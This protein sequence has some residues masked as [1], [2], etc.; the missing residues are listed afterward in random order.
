M[1]IFARGLA[2]CSVWLVA[3]RLSLAADNWPQWRGPTNDGIST[4]K[5][6]PVEWSE[7]QQVAWKLPLPGMGGSTPALWGDRLFLTSEEG[8][9]VVV[10]CVSTAGKV[11]WK[12]KVGSGRA[13]FRVDEANQAS[14]S[15]SSDGR[16]VYAF[17]GNGDFVCLDFDGHE[18]WRFDVQKRYGRFDIQ[19]GMHVTPLLDGD[20]LYL[21]LMHS[22][23]WWVIALD[24][25]TGKEIWKVRRE[26]DA[27]AENE[28]SYASPCMWRRGDSAYLIVH[29]CDYTTA[30]RLNDG[31][32]IWRVGGLNPKEKYNPTL[33]LVASPVA[34]SDLIV[35]PTAKNGPVVGLRPDARGQVGPGNDFEQWRRPANTPDVPSPLVHDGLVYLCRENGVLICMDAKTGQELY[36]ERL[37]NARYRASPVFADGKVYL[38][39]RDGKFTVVKAGRQFERL[40]VNALPDQFAASPVVSD[41]RIYLRGFGTLYAIGDGGK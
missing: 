2:I 9:D 34:T 33:R 16:H 21:A 29:G 5:N 3:G 27:Y 14:P 13:R 15:P 32:E 38:T 18:V 6:V 19:H 11:L 8:D 7:S 25:A 22:G 20:R 17:F 30:H 31:G 4:A 1:N 10:L 39:S 41:G 12:H 26:S 23:A 24:K 36:Q 40:A 28:H 35:I 37:H